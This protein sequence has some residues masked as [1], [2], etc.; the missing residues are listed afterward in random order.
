MP[1]H[2]ASLSIDGWPNHAR[3]SI[4]DAHGHY[5]SF[6]LRANHPTEPRAFWIRY[7][8]FSPKGRPRDAIGELWA[9]AFDGASNEHVV[10]KREMSIA[11]G[12]FSRDRFEVK[13][14]DATLDARSLVGS[15]AD[16]GHEIHW[17]LRYSSDASPLLLFPRWMYD[18]P[19]PRAKALVGAPN[20]TFEGELVVDGKAIDVGGWRGSQNHNWG[21]Q[22]TDR[23]AWAQV[24]G[25]DEAPDSFLE[26]AT[27]RIKV[28][29]VWTPPMTPMVLRHRGEEI[30]LNTLGHALRARGDF[31]FFEWRFSSKTR[32]LLV[33]G[34]VAAPRESF[35]GLR[36]YNPPGGTKH[37]LNSKL[38]RCT[39]R[40]KRG[41]AT[42]TLTCRNRAAFELLTDQRDHGVPI[43]A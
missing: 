42:E 19:L 18:A 2:E 24:C 30:A 38:A 25:F 13:L 16:R 14:G 10:C 21:S 37:C 9:I 36:Y 22:H 8:V 27:A 3:F 43:R 17:N 34:D 40:I 1:I 20:A 11:L 29:P 5:E 39:L 28:G 7:T 15:I 26:V 4:G 41:G 32:E 12:S 33:M 35:V 31:R 23:Y 6:F